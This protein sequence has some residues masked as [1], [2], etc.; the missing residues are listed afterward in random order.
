M[1]HPAKFSEGFI[2]IFYEL[3]LKYLPFCN[4]ILDPFAGTGKIGEIKKYGYKGIVIANELEPEWLEPNQFYCDCLYFSDAEFLNL[5]QKVDA[6]ITSPTYGNRMADH[7]NAKDDSK[8][9]TYTHCLGHQLKDGNTGK[10]QWGSKYKE[11]HLRIYKHLYDLLNNNG[12]F[13]LNVSNHIRKGQE[14][15]VAQWHKELLQNIG[16]ILLEKISVP[17][18]RMKFG[19]NRSNRVNNEYI[20]VFKKVEDCL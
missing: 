2:E 6:I 11:K 10:M 20:F 7:H 15:L 9:I 16:F 12:I 5:P 8:R 1:K 4:S 17:T 14:V 3:L 19:A 18:K 13:I